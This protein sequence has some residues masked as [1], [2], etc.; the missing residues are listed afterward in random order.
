MFR[1]RLAPVF[2]A[3]V[4]ALIFSGI[5]SAAEKTT[6]MPDFSMMPRSEIPVEYTWR[7]E[8]I[9]PTYDDWLK[10]KEAVAQLVPRIDE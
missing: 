2:A 8:D 7:V 5:T 1:S 10:D 3:L 6:E 9:Y 4:L